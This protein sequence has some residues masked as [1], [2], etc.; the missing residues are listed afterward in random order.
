M[1][2]THGPGHAQ[3]DFGEALAVIGG[4]E[5][6][7][8]YFVLDLP[9]SDWLL[10]EGLPGRDHRGLSGRPR[11]GLHLP[12]RFSPEHVCTTIPSWRWRRSWATA[13][14]SEPGPSPSSSPTTC[15]RT[16]SDVPA[17]AMTRGRWKGWWATPGAI[18]W[19]P[20]PGHGD[21]HRAEW[22]PGTSDAWRGWTPCSGATP[23]PSASGWSGTWRRCCRC[24]L[25][26]TSPVTSRLPGS[27]PCPW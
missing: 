21:L 5:R 25:P 19:C 9:H 1:P 7:V 20:C 14:A 11:V 16:G 10:R 26:P 18:S 15:S 4:V 24:R 17:R 13:G 22:P 2:L 12:G 6:K 23:R 27:V 8:H 3:C